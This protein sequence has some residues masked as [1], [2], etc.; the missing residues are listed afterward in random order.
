MRL[1]NALLLALTLV[2]LMGCETDMNRQ[3]RAVPPVASPSGA[4]PVTSPSG[5]HLKESPESAG[6]L[7]ARQRDSG[8]GGGRQV[9]SRGVAGAPLLSR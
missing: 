3:S 4:P 8:S 7:R 1:L 2:T 5:E 9:G 6:D